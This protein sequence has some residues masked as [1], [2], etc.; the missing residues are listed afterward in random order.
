MYDG[1]DGGKYDSAACSKI[2]ESEREFH[3]F[4]SLLIQEQMEVAPIIR[5]FWVDTAYLH[6]FVT[7][8]EVLKN[9]IISDPSFPGPKQVTKVLQFIISFS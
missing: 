5:I 6:L 7:L 9:G 1:G 8:Q 3:E 4:S 2:Y